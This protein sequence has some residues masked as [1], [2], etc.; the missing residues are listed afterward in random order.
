MQFK[1]GLRYT[2][3]IICLISELEICYDIVCLFM[4]LITVLTV[5]VA[6]EQ[7]KDRKIIKALEHIQNSCNK[8]FVI[9]ETEVEFK[10]YVSNV[11]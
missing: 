3:C 4:T 9:K 1:V 11:I 10:F 2:L 5:R 7:R 8:D 6:D